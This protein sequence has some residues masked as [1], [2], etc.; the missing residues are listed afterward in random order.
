[1]EHRLISYNCQRQN[2]CSYSPH[3]YATFRP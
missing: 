2:W 3:A 1:M